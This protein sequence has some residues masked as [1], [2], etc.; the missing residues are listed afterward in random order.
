ML[1]EQLGW[2]ELIGVA[3]D[4]DA[5]LDIIERHKP[6]IALI[7]LSLFGTTTEHILEFIKK[8]SATTHLIALTMLSDEHKAQ[9]LLT[10]GLS[11]YVLKDT[12]FEDLIQAIQQVGIGDKITSSSL[13]VQATT[14]NVMNDMPHL[15]HRESEV[16]MCVANGDRNKEIA[17]KLDITQR[18]VC[19]H[20]TNCFAKLRVTNRTQAIMKAM[21]HGLIDVV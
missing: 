18:T 4:M 14:P 21:T 8:N 5:T 20:M 16:L 15:T 1:L 9:Q 12:A 3:T 7:A 11:G 6:K 19:F 10:C 2:L 17:Y 13:V